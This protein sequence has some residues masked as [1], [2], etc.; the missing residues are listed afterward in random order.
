MEGGREGE[1]EGG[2]EEVKIKFTENETRQNN[3]YIFFKNTLRPLPPSLLPSL[4]ASYLF[5]DGPRLFS[6]WSRRGG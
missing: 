3:I 4:P 2:I 6:G 1:R 5:L